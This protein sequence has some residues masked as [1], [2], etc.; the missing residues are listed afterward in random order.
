MDIYKFLKGLEPDDQGRL[1]HQIW[2]FSDIEAGGIDIIIPASLINNNWPS[3]ANN[4]ANQITWAK[5]NFSLSL[6]NQTSYEIKH[7]SWF[8]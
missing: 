8:C 3:T 2:N 6:P 1:I 7:I 4:T 5:Y